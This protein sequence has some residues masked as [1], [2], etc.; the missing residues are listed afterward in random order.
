MIIHKIAIT[1][2]LF[3]V[4]SVN[5]QTKG[6]RKE[7]ERAERE[8]VERVMRYYSTCTF[9]DGLRISRTDR[10]QRGGVRYLARPTAKDR[11]ER[12]TPEGRNR[13]RYHVDGNGV[14]Y[15]GVSRTYGIRVMTDY[16]K[17]EFF[18]N[19]RVDKANPSEYDEDKSILIRWLNF[20]HSQRPDSATASP[21]E[22]NYNGI[23]TL[24]TYRKDVDVQKDELG[25]SVIFDDANRIYT[26]I[27]FL[28]QRPRYRVH[29]TTEEWMELRERFLARYTACIKKSERSN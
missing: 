21:I 29:K 14:L 9:E 25:I 12:G 23:V 28:N 15:E 27:Y 6:S 16:G 13:D 2:L 19:I 26:S 24:S 10:I 5:G 20:V 7:A 3:A 1:V 8:E 22:S 18:A 17:P 11:A 4:F